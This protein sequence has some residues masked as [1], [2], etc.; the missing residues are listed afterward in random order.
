ME[1]SYVGLFDLDAPPLWLVEA[2]WLFV[3][4]EFWSSVTW[5]KRDK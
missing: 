5:Q 1:E 4:F 3:L 2:Q